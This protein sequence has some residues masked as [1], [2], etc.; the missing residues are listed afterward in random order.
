MAFAKKDH[1]VGL[2]IGS[3]CIKV[4]EMETAKTGWALKKFGM[5]ELEPN[6]I[7]DGIIKD[8]DGVSDAIKTL[9][10]DHHIKEKKVAV[11]IGGYSIIVK[12]INVQT[13]TEAQLLETIHFEA[14]QYIPFDIND[15]NLDFQILGENENNPNQMNVLLVAAKKDLIDDYLSVV[16][17]A[18]R[19]ASI[20][21]VDAFALQNIY[22]TNYLSTGETADE[23]DE[24]PVTLLDIGASKTS[25]NILSGTTSLFMRDISLG[26]SQINHEIM[27]QSE[28]SFQDA[29][30]IKSGNSD[31]RISEANVTSILSSFAEEWV[32][33]IRRALDFFYSSLGDREIDKILLGGGGSNMNMLRELLSTETELPIEIIN[34]FENIDIGNHKHD[35]SYLQQ[36]APQAAIAMG[37]ALRR[38]DDK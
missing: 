21:D 8:R 4:A 29:E 13:M 5:L 12:K 2:D 35:A 19:H 24:I 38:V 36:V 34:P 23:T 26:C 37:L 33:E 30:R 18:G 31:D 27:S 3:Q 16:Q 11:S 9:F 25:L 14:E 7:E 1:L 17:S 6:L 20:I 10:K 22:E 28:C 32:T 15:V